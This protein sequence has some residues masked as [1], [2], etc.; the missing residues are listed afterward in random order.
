MKYKLFVK[1]ATIIVEVIL[2]LILLMTFTIFAMKPEPEIFT[3]ALLLILILVQLFTV[4]MLM[5]VYE[6][7]EKGGKRK[8][9]ESQM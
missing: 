3:N 7:L 9:K 8:W 1:I 5:N 2:V 4:N 6:K